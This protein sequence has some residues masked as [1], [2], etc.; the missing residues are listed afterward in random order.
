MGTA[1]ALGS[2]GVALAVALTRQCL[3]VG[4][5][6]H[7]LGRVGWWVLRQVGCCRH[8]LLGRD[9]LVALVR[10]PGVAGWHT[11]RLR[12]R[13]VHHGGGSG[14][15]HDR[16]K[17]NPSQHPQAC[18][19][20]LQLSPIRGLGGSP[21]CLGAMHTGPPGCLRRGRRHILYKQQQEQVKQTMMVTTKST[22]M[23]RPMAIVAPNLPKSQS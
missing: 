4:R 21:C 17:E 6:A 23:V 9:G 7:G 2:G 3:M 15:G 1:G 22:K 12:V 18:R 13:G 10:W 16:C 20:S 19:P 8:P 11:W 5:R 14:G